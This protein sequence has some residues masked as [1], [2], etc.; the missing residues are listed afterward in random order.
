VNRPAVCVNGAGAGLA[1]V[2]EQE[3]LEVRKMFE[4]GG[5]S[6]SS[7]VRLVNLRFDYKAPFSLRVFLSLCDCFS[8]GT[9]IAFLIICGEAKAPKYMKYAIMPTYTQ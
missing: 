5:E 6:L 9:G 2:W 8:T 3:K 1:K 7:S 4:N